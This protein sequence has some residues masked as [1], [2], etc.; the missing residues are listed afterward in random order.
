MP[1]GHTAE[2]EPGVFGGV[3]QAV[4][5]LLGA[6]LRGELGRDGDRHPD[7]VDEVSGDD[8][9][10]ALAARLFLPLMRK[11]SNE[12]AVDRRG[13][14]RGIRRAIVEIAPEVHIGEHE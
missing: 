12:I 10:P 3:T 2:L 14:A 8:D 5:A 1:D 7:E 6:R 4:R 11:K 13:S 9:A